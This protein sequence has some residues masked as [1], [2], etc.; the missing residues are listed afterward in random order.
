MK[1]TVSLSNV[2]TRKAFRK[3]NM[4]NVDGNRLKIDGPKIVR[5]IRGDYLK[6]DRS[7]TEQPLSQEESDQNADHDIM[8]TQEESE[9]EQVRT[10]T[11]EDTKAMSKI[12]VSMS[13]DVIFTPYTDGTQYACRRDAQ[14]NLRRRM[15]DFNVLLS[16][17][18]GEGQ[19]DFTVSSVFDVEGS[20]IAVTARGIASPYEMAVH[21][22]TVNSGSQ[23]IEL[24]PV[25]RA[26][27]PEDTVTFLKRVAMNT[28]AGKYA[29][30]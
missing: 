24:N 8:P 12:K 5:R 4:D 16:D 7:L 26:R 19:I 17:V 21:T 2:A 27:S 14:A 11:E 23:M 28:L 13:G 1:I 25:D 18:T 6:K 22:V 10:D 20:K 15:P 30:S 9:I 29:A 3:S